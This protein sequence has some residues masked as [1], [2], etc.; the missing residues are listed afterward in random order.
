MPNII[1]AEM[2][3]KF[4]PK[5][6][7]LLSQFMQE[8]KMENETFAMLLALFPSTSFEWARSLESGNYLSLS[9]VIQTKI[10][11][12][13]LSNSLS[14]VKKLWLEGTKIEI[15]KSERLIL[16]QYSSSQDQSFTFTDD[17]PLNITM[18]IFIP[19]LYPLKRPQVKCCYLNPQ[20]S[21]R[22]ER[23]V[24]GVCSTEESLEAGILI[25]RKEIGI[26]QTNSE[27]DPCS[28]CFDY[29]DKSQNPPLLK[30]KTCSHF[31]HRSCF[32]KW[33]TKCLRPTCP[34]C[35]SFW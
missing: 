10:S 25:W 31:V 32:Q 13:I 6:P 22:L 27:K 11:D 8:K 23:K 14:S 18:K 7:L 15:K 16:C 3:S 30:C 24:L 17:S 21:E 9:K 26:S 1:R 33:V 5:L 19:V 35:G 4:A 29:Y 34:Y 2:K 20:H 28:I 12:F